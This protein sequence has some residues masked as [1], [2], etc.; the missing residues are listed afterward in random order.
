MG[1]SKSAG[2]AFRL[3]LTD[4]SAAQDKDYRWLSFFCSEKEEKHLKEKR[5]LINTILF[6]DKESFLERLPN[7]QNVDLAIH[8]AAAAESPVFFQALMK[9]GHSAATAD[10]DGYLPIHYAAK[11]GR[12]NQILLYKR[13]PEYLNHS[14]ASGMTPLYLAVQ[15][16]QFEVVELLLQL[17]A[18]PNTKTTYGMSPLYSAVHNGHEKIAL[19][20]IEHE[21]T[22]VDL[23]VE[24]KSTPLFAA[25]EGN[26]RHVVNALLNRGADSRIQRR[27]TYTPLHVAAK[28]GLF[29]I[30]R[31][32]LLAD[33]DVNA[34]LKSGKTALHL[35]AEGSPEIVNLLLLHGADP[36]LT[37]WDGST[38]L[39]S[40][41]ING[42][43][44]SAEEIIHFCA[45]SEP[46]KKILTYPDLKGNTPLFAAFARKQYPAKEV[47]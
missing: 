35:A 18:N 13:V 10:P 2:H 36:S 6:E 20:L 42:D 16:N 32:L 26:M 43:L 9:K 28:K 1:D 33:V 47:I 30:C 44:S 45:Q 29:K 19:K 15:Y 46:L 11:A 25:I 8:H 17:N 31:R 3:H 14:S 24:D 27:D 37:G 21:R 22:A 41:I 5:E 4:F 40:A 39:M 38:P 7:F 12:V 23:A 34:R